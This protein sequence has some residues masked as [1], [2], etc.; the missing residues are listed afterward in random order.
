MLFVIFLLILIVLVG[1]G[2][3]GFR[4]AVWVPTFG[5]DV[6]AMLDDVKL[7]PGELFV[8][9]GCGDGRML[10]AA[11]KRGA[12]VVGYEI[13]PVLWLVATV[14][15]LRHRTVRVRLGDLWLQDLSQADVVMTFLMQRFMLRLETKLQK[16]LHPGARF[17]TY[18][19]TLPN[20]KAKIA[21]HHWWVYQ[22]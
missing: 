22:Y 13:N 3:S 16:E 12:K 14:R 6:E 17:A 19:F 1:F 11:A 10:V 4:G 2:V 20:K 15:T 7:R 8:E 21:R 9:L 5:R 18:V